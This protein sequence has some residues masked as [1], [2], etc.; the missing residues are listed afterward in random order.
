MNLEFSLEELANLMQTFYF[1]DHHNATHVWFEFRIFLT[2]IESVLSVII[3]IIII[4]TRLVTC[5]MS[6][7]LK[8]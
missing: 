6:I 8:R 5:H 1:C 4:I 7:A 3:I 2:Y